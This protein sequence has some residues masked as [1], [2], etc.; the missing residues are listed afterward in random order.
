M[1]MTF[2]TQ[3]LGAV[4]KIDVIFCDFSKMFWTLSTTPR[5][6]IKVKGYGISSRI[7]YYDKCAVSSASSRK[8]IKDLQAP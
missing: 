5:L 3:V 2:I 1:T 4:E 8:F 6:L 7:T